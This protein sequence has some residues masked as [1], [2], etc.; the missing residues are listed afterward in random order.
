MSDSTQ[1]EEQP[2]KH[3]VDGGA[4]LAD[5]A[6]A[7]SVP[8]FPCDANKR[9]LTRHGFKDATADPAEIRRLFANPAAVM[10]GMPT[11]EVTAVV[12]VD[13]D[14]KEG[15]QGRIW[16]DANSHRLPQTWTVRTAS[17]GLHLYFR[18][19]EQPIRNSA[20][21]IAPGIDVRG[22]GGYVIVPP[23]PG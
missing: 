7:L 14:V 23:S 12:V 6:V 15:R 21:K 13:I 18:W 9:P 22:D 17:G 2:R 19:P 1:F 3:E 16:L 8:V 20:S 10:I 11:G 4:G 5:A